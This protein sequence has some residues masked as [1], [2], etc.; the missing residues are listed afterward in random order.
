MF[1]VI[2]TSY[3]DIVFFFPK[4][5]IDWSNISI[6]MKC[7]NETLY[8]ILEECDHI[9]KDMTTASFLDQFDQAKFSKTSDDKNLWDLILKLLQL[10]L[11]KLLLTWDIM[12]KAIVGEGIGSLIARYLNHSLSFEQTVKAIIVTSRWYLK[13][14]GQGKPQ[15]V[16]E[17]LEDIKN[18]IIECPSNLNETIELYCSPLHLGDC[19]SEDDLGVFDP[20]ELNQILKRFSDNQS[21]PVR[22]VNFGK[23]PQSTLLN[24]F[25]NN[26]DLK[27]SLNHL[28]GT[29]YISGYPLDFKEFMISNTGWESLP[30]YPW[31]HESYWISE[32]YE[33][34]TEKSIVKPIADPITSTQETLSSQPDDLKSIITFA[35][36]EIL[37][38]PAERVRTEQ[39]MFEIGVDS[40]SAARLI[41]NLQ[42]KHTLTLT[43]TDLLREGSIDK[44]TQWLER[45]LKDNEVSDNKNSSQDLGWDTNFIDQISESDALALEE[46]LRKELLS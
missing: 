4:D 2:Y 15:L 35:V 43:F 21:E 28:L 18:N 24:I 23:N 16:M 30:T 12:P 45:T 39:H 17:I 31:Q 38:I 3:E 33:K 1:V 27:E 11:A 14:H 7:S 22:V 8:K 25:N 9:L 46:A 20:D 37:G 42:K 41:N 32:V 34:P 10:S 40:I 13:L 26:K 5:N 36:A 6:P 19:I 29:F 44:L